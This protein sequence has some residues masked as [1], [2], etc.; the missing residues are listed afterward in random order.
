MTSGAIRALLPDALLRDPWTLQER[1]AL[2]CDGEGRIVECLPP[3]D[4][5]RDRF[6]EEFPGEVWTAAPVL[7]HAHLE[8]FDAPSAD[9]DRSSFVAW[10]EA[11]LAWRTG[12]DRLTPEESAQRSLEELGAAGCGLV[13]SHVGEAGAEGH[14]QVGL[15]EAI[16]LPELFDPEGIGPSERQWEAA[17][18]AGGM[19]LHA[20]YSVA[21]EVAKEVFRAFASD[22]LVSVHLGEHAEER[23][24]L[25][26]GKGPMAELLARRGR[27]LRGRHWE[28][29]VD[30]LESVE[31]A[32]PGCLA[33]HGGDLKAEELQ[34]LHG[35]G[36]GLVFCPGT[37]AYFER[38]AP[39]F[40]SA[41]IPMPALGCDSRASNQSLDPLRELA[42]A[43]RM[44]PTPGA[45]AWWEALT[46]RGAWMLRRGDLGS[47]QDGRR[48]RVLRLEGVP[49][50]A[51][52]SAEAMC[53]FLCETPTGPRRVR[54]FTC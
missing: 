9:W 41:G 27:T 19:A 51:R 45:Q 14:G 18:A 1:V 37:H 11:L 2:C 53:T 29:P 24:F 22:G 43:H 40:V 15:P 20:P 44:M 21:H 50:A 31:G 28:S 13:L 5:P 23:Q 26:A 46:L 7:A 32:R 36:V 54:D 6:V 35:R 3:E 25:E 47:L 17:R 34:R 52:A 33:V 49:E 10:V 4:L 12:A 39:E 42:M 16:G 8:S 30:W 48:A 38:P